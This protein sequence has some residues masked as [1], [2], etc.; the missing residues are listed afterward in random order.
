MRRKFDLRDVL[1]RVLLVAA[2]VIAAAL[3]VRQGQAHALPA[4]AIG[5]TIGVF[6]M[7]GVQTGEER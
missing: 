6:C 2:G 5:A 3:F 4:L 1:M 7:T